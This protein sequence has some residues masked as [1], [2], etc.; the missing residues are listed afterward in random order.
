VEAEEGARPLAPRVS[1]TLARRRHGQPAAV[2]AR[3]DLSSRRLH[4]RWHA[5]EQRGKRRTVVAVAVAR[6]LVAHCWAL[7]TM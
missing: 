7:A 2:R 1:A 4:D 3:A 6:E 5:L